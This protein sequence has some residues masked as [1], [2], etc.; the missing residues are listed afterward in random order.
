MEEDIQNYSPTVMFRGTPCMSNTT[1]VKF[2]R[3]CRFISKINFSAWWCQLLK[4]N[5]FVADLIYLPYLTLSPFL[6]FPP[7]FLHLLPLGPSPHWSPTAFTHVLLY[8]MIDII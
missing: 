8:K 3:N 1:L 6:N 2:F 5:F 7:T 4:S